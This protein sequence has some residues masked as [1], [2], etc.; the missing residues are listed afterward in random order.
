MIFARRGIEIERYPS[1]LRY[2]EYHRPQLEPKPDSWKPAKPGDDW[3][4]RKPGSYAWYEIQDAVDYWPDFQKPKIIYQEI[5]Y[6]PCYA[7]D[8]ACL[9]GNNKTFLLP[10]DDTI[11]LAILNSPIM[12]WFNWRFMPHMKD[13]ALTPVG[14]K[15]EHL[16][17]AHLKSGNDKSARSLVESLIATA[18]SIYQARVSTIDWLRIE[19][20]VDKLGALAAPHTLEVDDFIAAVR[21][22]LPKPRKLSTAEIARV[23]QEYTTTIGPARGAAAEALALERRLSE[24]VNAAYGL[25]PD[26]VKLMWDTAP[27][28]MPFGRMAGD[29]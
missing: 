27:P 22:A 18:K 17:I 11:L 12:W 19:F 26:E 16:P 3:P 20:G 8:I 25:T 6:H 2:L 14:F 7:L 28:R 9:F 10:S 1:V 13:E 5:Q 24:L 4:G 15:M 29:T 21:K 23:R